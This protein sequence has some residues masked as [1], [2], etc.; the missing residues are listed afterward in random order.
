MKERDSSNTQSIAGKKQ[1]IFC[2]Y[3]FYTTSPQSLFAGQSQRCLQ[4]P[5]RLH[6]QVWKFETNECTKRL[7][8]RSWNSAHFTPASDRTFTW[9]SFTKF[10]IERLWERPGHQVHPTFQ[11]QTLW[12]GYRARWDVEAL[13][14][15]SLY[16]DAMDLG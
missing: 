7:S 9:R 13:R 15:R 2:P 4:A 16:V 5:Q 14:G 8:S 3:I 10:G 1:M 6:E 12:Q 11:S